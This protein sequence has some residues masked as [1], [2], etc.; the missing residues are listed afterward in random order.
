VTPVSLRASAHACALSLG[1]GAAVTTEAR[2]QDPTRVVVHRAQIE[3]AGWFNLGEMLA[4]ATGW[5]RTTL[6][7]VSFLVA[8]EGLPPGAT[9]PSEPQWLV[10]IDGQRVLTDAYGARLLELLPVSPAQ[11]ESVTVTRVPRLIG[12]TIAGRGV[13]EFHTRRPGRGPSVDGAWNSGNVTGDPGP[14]A[15]TPIGGENVDRLGPYNHA[16]AGF[17]GAG[18]DVVAG[19]HQGSTHIT[20]RGIRERFD[21]ALY[22]QLGE[23]KWA[24]YD[25]VNARIGGS[26]LGGRHD[27]IAGRGWVNGPL[28]LPLVGEEQWLRGSLEHLG[29]SG[30]IETGSATVGYQLTHSSLDVRELPS[31]FP[32]VAGH[33]RERNAGVLDIG[34]ADEGGRH[35]RLGVSAARWKAEHNGASASRTDAALFGELTARI[36]RSD[37]DLSAALARSSGGLL[38]AKGVLA[39]SVNVDSS[40]AVVIAVS[41]V[42]HATGDDGTWIDRA[43]LGLDT[44]RRVRDARASLDLGATRRLGTGWLADVGARVGIVSGVRLLEPNG[45]AHPNA[46]GGLAE[47]RAALSLPMTTRVPVARVAYRFATPLSGDDDLRDALRATPAHVL[48]GSFATAVARDFRLG[49]FVYF[50]SRA[51]WPALRGGAATPS[52]LP[53]I[54]RLDLSAEKWFWRHRV[55]TQLLLRNLLDRPERYHPLGADL[56]LRAHVTVGLAL[57]AR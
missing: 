6:D 18:W 17:G 45:V 7:A 12:G 29:A 31:P 41:F 9:A 23:N 30:T 3:S 48:E 44:L 26:L 52:V 49:A 10:L 21:P 36:G 19:A 35:A 57:P 39:S 1:L 34:I 27:V 56:P 20:H 53:A 47:L 2:S 38:V 42:Q 51:R 16:F 5:H 54:S 43:L 14:Y 46:D 4:G 37:N 15:Y 11:I 13:V 50:A 40:T 28:F 24:P 32:F 55:R 22:E 25:A 33:S 8:P